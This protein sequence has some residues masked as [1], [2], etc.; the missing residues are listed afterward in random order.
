KALSEPELTRTRAENGALFL[1]ARLTPQPSIRDTW[2]P[3]AFSLQLSALSQ[4]FF[5]KCK[6]VAIG[7]NSHSVLFSWGLTC[8]FPPQ[9]PAPLHNPAILQVLLSTS[10]RPSPS[11]LGNWFG[12]FRLSVLDVNGGFG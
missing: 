6:R 8:R 2:T 12:V 1:L 11:L 3:R 5:A 4:N 10:W 7:Q 9:V